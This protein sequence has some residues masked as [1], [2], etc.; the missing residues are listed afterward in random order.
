MLK[1]EIK[2]NLEM[3]KLVGKMAFIGLS[4]TVTNGLT[5]GLI[6]KWNAKKHVDMATRAIENTQQKLGHI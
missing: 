1:E 6:S 5:F 2:Y 3:T 4:F